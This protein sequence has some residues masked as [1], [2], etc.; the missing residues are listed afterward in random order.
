MQRVAVLKRSLILATCLLAIVVQAKAFYVHSP[1]LLS[2]SLN[3]TPASFNQK[4]TMT[5]SKQEG[6]GDDDEQEE[7]EEEFKV[8]TWNPL[9]L[10]VLRLGLTEPGYTSPFNYQKKDGAF[11]CAYC[12]KELFDS[13]AKYDSGS[14]WPSFWRSIDDGAINYKMEFDGRLECR[15]KRCT[16][17]LGHVFL[18]GPRQRDV[19][20]VLLQNIPPT[21]P[22]TKQTNGRLPRFC[23]NGAAL[24]L[25][26]IS[27]ES[28]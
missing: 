17:H 19:P 18:D 10:A 5:F 24:T 6:K 25:K 8:Q 20:Q 21:D 2:S 9:R 26:E 27:E 12:G 16:S 11:A 13:S 7:K 4:K 15:C 3:N 22:R 28:E 14:G 1:A 23:I